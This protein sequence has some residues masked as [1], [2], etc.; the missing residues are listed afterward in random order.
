[1]SS[2]RF[3]PIRIDFTS[4]PVLGFTRWTWARRRAVTQIADG[5]VVI[6]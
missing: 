2:L 5:L 1:M 6:E 3:A 4:S